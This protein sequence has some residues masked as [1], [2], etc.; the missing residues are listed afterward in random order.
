MNRRIKTYLQEFG[1]HLFGVF[2]AWVLLI[3]LI[4]ADAVRD[5]KSL[6]ASQMTCTEYLSSTTWT[7]PA[8]VTW[9]YVTG[10]GGGGGGGGGAK[11]T[12]ASASSSWG[13]GGGGAAPLGF[14]VV[15]LTPNTLMSITVSGG[16]SGGTS[17]TVS[18]SAAGTGQNGGSSIFAVDGGTNL[19]VFSGGGAGTGGTGL[20][21]GG[22]GGCTLAT[23]S[24]ASTLVA[25][26]C[27]TQGVD[28]GTASAGWASAVCWGT[29]GASTGGTSGTVVTNGGG[30]GGGGGAGGPDGAG[31]NG[32]TGPAGTSGSNGTV[33]VDGGDAGANTGA[34]GGG[35]S[36]GSAGSSTAG[37]GGV[38]GTGGSGDV[39]VC[40]AL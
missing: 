36:G 14:G 8:G 2:A 11:G 13:G 31:G 39:R 38:G 16:G 30:G 5:A 19:I 10:F 4:A 26:G 15:P 9:A 7:V 28:S 32:A 18:G 22:F 6:H 20:T 35:G 33:G 17:G 27:G 34:G 3:G 12:S 1:R 37:D 21:D 25:N 40:Y 24:P 29:C 23:L